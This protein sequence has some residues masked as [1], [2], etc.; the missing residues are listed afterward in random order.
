MI[1]HP[2]SPFKGQRYT[3]PVEL[4]DVFPTINDLLGAPF[5][6]NHIYGIATEGKKS[7]YGS[8]KFVPLQGKSLAPL[9]LGREFKYRTG[10]T[11]SKTI[12]RGDSMPV[13]N[14]TFALSQ[15]W[16]CARNEDTMVDSRIDS[17]V[18]Q[19]EVRWDSCDIEERKGETSLMGYSM[20]TLDFRYTMYIPFLRPHQLPIW[21]L[22]IFSEELYDHR[23]GYLGDL[24]HFEIVN[25]ASDKNYLTLLVKHRK[26]MRDFL[27]NEVVYVN[28]TR[29]HSDTSKRLKKV[30]TT[31][32]SGSV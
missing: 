23:K 5:N 6:K 27:W 29:T 8:R 15:V 19:H 25:L 32:H 13:L 14:Q 31:K 17:T 2:Q 12:F 20:R 24:G 21:D 26:I 7:H 18:S 4:I 16:R 10:K 9:I 1:A 30:G 3:H 22:P 11:N 28:L